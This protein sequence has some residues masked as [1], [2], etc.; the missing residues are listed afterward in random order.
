MTRERGSLRDLVDRPATTD[1]GSGSEPQLDIEGLLELD[2]VRTEIEAALADSGINVDRY[3]RVLKS[4]PLGEPRLLLVDPAEL[5]SAYIGCA[6]LGLEPNSVLEHCFLRAIPI[7]D[8]RAC[9]VEFIM[10]YKG[11]IALA[12]R[13]P[14]IE[15]IEAHVIH[16]FDRFQFEQ[17]TDSYLM[18][19]WEIDEPRGDPKGYYGIVRF[20]NGG[21]PRFWPISLAEI[22]EH[23]AYSPTANDPG[24][25]WNTRPIQMALKTVIRIMF[26]MLPITAEAL[27]AAGADGRVIGEISP[28]PEPDPE[29][30]SAPEPAA[31]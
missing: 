8:S 29:P 13:S 12:Y 27:E 6:Q 16:Q 19:D 18:H 11:M 2:E 15:S 9:A 22:E 30:G 14:Q 10:G 4:A 25:L 26:P 24:S 7:P 1:P 21:R 17:G 23:K 31:A 3:M 28:E 20:T 5:L